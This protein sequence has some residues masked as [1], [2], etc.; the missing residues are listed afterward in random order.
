MRAHPSDCLGEVAPIGANDVLSFYELA[1]TIVETS[2]G[3]SGKTLF[4]YGVVCRSSG[5]LYL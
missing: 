3:A 4:K 2:D 5:E 1:Y